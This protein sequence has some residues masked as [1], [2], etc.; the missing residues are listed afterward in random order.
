MSSPTMM[1]VPV[2]SDASRRPSIYP[3]CLLSSEI[4]DLMWDLYM[5]MLSVVERERV[6]LLDDLTFE[7]FV[8]ICVRHTDGL[9]HIIVHGDGDDDGVAEAVPVTS[10]AATAAA[11]G[12]DE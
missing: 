7:Q 11:A 8:D 9:P 5:G 3:R 12:S 4:Q 2:V 10:A 1:P 6:V